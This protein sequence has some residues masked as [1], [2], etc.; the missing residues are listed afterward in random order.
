MRTCRA[1]MAKL[2]GVLLL[3]ALCNSTASADELITYTYDARGRLVQVSRSGAVN[4]GVQANYAYD[5]ADN[6]SNVTVTGAPSGSALAAAPVT[7]QKGGQQTPEQ[8]SPQGTAQ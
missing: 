5:K 8:Q 3:A 7:T 1:G 6:R 4:N 2:S